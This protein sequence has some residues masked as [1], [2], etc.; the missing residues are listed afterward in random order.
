M[1]D[2]WIIWP[3]WPLDFRTLSPVVDPAR[4]DPELSSIGNPKDDATLFREAVGLILKDPFWTDPPRDPDA[5]IEAN[6]A[7]FKIKG[8]IKVENG[9]KELWPY[10]VDRERLRKQ[11]PHAIA[12]D[13]LTQYKKQR[14][15]G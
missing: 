10:L 6:P 2:P 14:E 3:D 12:R 4:A 1:W 13:F 5:V 9:E 15:L 7:A 8:L 11:G